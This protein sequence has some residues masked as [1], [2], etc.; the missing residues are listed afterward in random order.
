MGYIN[1]HQPHHH[2]RQPLR[3]EDSSYQGRLV[4]AEMKVA[5]LLLLGALCVLVCSA[6]G[7]Y[8]SSL[9]FDWTRKP[10]SSRFPLDI[11]QWVV[12]CDCAGKK[13]VYDPPTPPP[14]A[15]LIT[16]KIAVAPPSK[17][18]AVLPSSKKVTQLQHCL[19][20]LFA[21]LCS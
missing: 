13:F 21:V 2:T 9:S 12:V 10:S 3:T 20:S 15:P 4:S 5:Q 6:S 16:K 19:I 7:G 1:L 17:K 11:I 8:C 18:I 14:P